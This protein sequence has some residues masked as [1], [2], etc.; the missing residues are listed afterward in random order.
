MSDIA[1]QFALGMLVGT[2]LFGMVALAGIQDSPDNN[3]AGSVSVVVG[4]LLAI[5]SL[6]VLIGFIHH[7]VRLIQAPNVVAAVARDLDASFNQLF[8]DHIGDGKESDLD[9]TRFAL[10]EVGYGSPVKSKHEGYLQAIDSEALLQLA[11]SYELV[12]RLMVKPGEFIEHGQTLLEVWPEEVVRPVSPHATRDTHQVSSSGRDYGN[13]LTQRINDAIIAGPR[14]TPRQDAECALDELIEVAVRAL[15]PGIN[16]PFTAMSCLDRI[17]ASLGRVAERRMPT[18]HRFDDSGTPRIISRV[19]SF[20]GLMDASFNQIRQHGCQC[21]AVAIRML[22]ALIRIAKHVRQPKQK[23]S[24]R[25][26]AKMLERDFREHVRQPKD[27]DEF[28]RHYDE[29]TKL[30]A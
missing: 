27:G 8:P 12:I 15:S 5:V 24:I 22:S 7:V 6:A 17:A 25:R 28:Q 3:S 9:E 26:H 30:L 14:R 13:E 29:L 21:V 23:E 20:D 1:T 16:D 11:T 19:A 10:P 4:L 2:S 18:G